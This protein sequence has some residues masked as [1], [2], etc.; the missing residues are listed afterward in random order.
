MNKEEI[1]QTIS[2]FVDLIE[3]GRGSV[4][5]NEKSLSLLLDK[6]ALAS[7]FVNDSKGQ[8]ADLKIPQIDSTKL[9]EIVSN[10]FPKYG[11]YNSPNDVTSKITET[12][13]TVGDAIDDILDITMELK[14]VLFY[15]DNSSSENAL[16]QYQNGFNNHWA[17]HLRELQLYILANKSA[18]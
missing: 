9:R 5:E 10:R 11:Y 16:F 15:W 2:D 17:L 18:A 1:Y 4:E 13:I 12:E 3:N 8:S 6:L 14:T 7:H